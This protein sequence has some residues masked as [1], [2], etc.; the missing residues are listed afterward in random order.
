MD[1]G[2]LFAIY[3]STFLFLLSTYYFVG[4]D[5]LKQ[6]GGSDPFWNRV[7]LG[8]TGIATV[9]D[10]VAAVFI[11]ADEITGGSYYLVFGTVFYLLLQDAYITEVNTAS[12]VN[13]DGLLCASSVFYSNR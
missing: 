2:V 9:L 11:V 7:I 1:L 13:R 5:A 12:F 6:S 8:L 3:V 10:L 4:A